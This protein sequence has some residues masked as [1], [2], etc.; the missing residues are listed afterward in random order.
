MYF[1]NENSK[2]TLANERHLQAVIPIPDDWVRG[3]CSRCP[4]IL[5]NEEAETE[6]CMFKYNPK[7]ICGCRLNV[8]NTKV[9]N[10]K[11]LD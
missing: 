2:F 9:T 6:E 1:E 11:F 7:A 5:K 8:T 4:F 10:M 3:K